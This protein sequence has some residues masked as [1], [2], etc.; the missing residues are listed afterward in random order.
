MNAR[1][2]N[3]VSSRVIALS[4]LRQQERAPNMLVLNNKNKLLSCTALRS[5]NKEECTRV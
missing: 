4:G 3:E 5:A 1:I 2:L